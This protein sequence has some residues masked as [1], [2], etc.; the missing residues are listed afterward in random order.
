MNLREVVSRGMKDLDVEAY[1]SY[2]VSRVVIIVSS[3]STSSARLTSLPGKS[4]D[5]IAFMGKKTT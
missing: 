5:V 1:L 4:V 2:A 3:A